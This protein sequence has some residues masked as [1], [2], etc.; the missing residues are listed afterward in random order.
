MGAR[1]FVST[2]TLAGRATAEQKLAGI[3]DGIF[4]APIDYRFAVRR[5]L[6]A[7]RPSLVVVLETEI[8][9]N[10]YREVKRTGSGLM[11]VNGRI[12]DRALPRYRKLRL[13]FRHVLA[14][15][16]AILVQT[17]KDRTRYVES[18]APADRVR[19]AGNLKFDFNP[20][21]EVANEI[22]ALMAR[23]S[24]AEVWIAASTMP[25]AE[26]GDVD[27]DDVVLA[28]FCELA[29]R[30]EGLLLILV[31][32][33]PERF[34][35]VE[36][37]LVAA[38]IRYVRRSQ[39][40]GDSTLALPGVLLLDTIGELSALFSIA[41]VVFM[42][43]TL[44]R[45]GGHNILEPAFFARPVIVGPH[46]ENFAAIAEE[47]L[48]H[49]A[50]VEI[51]RGSAVAGAVERL[52]NDRSLAAEIGERGRAL[53]EAERGA[54]ARIAEEAERWYFAGL[55]RV[56]RPALVHWPL[57]VLSWIWEAGSSRSRRQAMNERR[58]LNTPVISIGGITMGGTGKTPL[59]LLL[60][61][62]LRRQRLNP[63]ILTRGYRRRSIERHIVVAAGVQASTDLTGDEA[64]IFVRSGAAHVGIGANR[65]ETALLVEAQCRPDIFLLDDGF[66]HWRL[67]RQFDI[68]LIDALNPFGGGWTFPLGELREP[69]PA[70][71]R[72]NAFVITRVQP[73]QRTDAVE[74]EIR[75]HNRDAPI[76]RSRVIPRCW[77]ELEWGTQSGVD[78]P[79]LRRV[80]A[81]CGLANPAAFWRTLELLG[82]EILFRWTFA[83][84]HHYSPR[85]LQRLAAQARAHGADVLVTTEKDV[86]NFCQNAPALFAPARLYW[87]KIGVEVENEEELVNHALRL[88]A[89]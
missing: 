48:A 34:D 4:Y 37:K 36:Q 12:S 73:G 78:T 53:A 65:Y 26:S 51:A 45:R 87:L 62:R 29:P 75:R 71:A 67:D 5:V 38:G 9:P 18:G 63:A 42:G 85:E 52:L 80:A 47:F 41:D 70:L 28:A 19:V 2:T 77:V 69:L 7:L 79:A 50:V 24:P 20:R 58:R 82:L 31:P 3:A 14:W 39:L 27:E 49:S 21:A 66:Q 57:R 17:E 23:T 88:V 22:T 68:V 16:N 74:N 84:H 54:A 35:V 40:R 33:R 76:F 44:A 86:M 13:F 6:R 15:P 89:R 8:W 1:L 83:D 55:P 81:F 25:P 59:V 61:E 11:V 30:R 60:A 10:L 46:M 56:M 43:G 72:A 32:R 64:Q